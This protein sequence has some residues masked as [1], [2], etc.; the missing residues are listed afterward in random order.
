MK[1]HRNLTQGP[2]A[3]KPGVCFVNSGD[4]KK[5]SRRNEPTD[6]HYDLLM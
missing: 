3:K 5:K 4:Q 6:L 2:F 1:N